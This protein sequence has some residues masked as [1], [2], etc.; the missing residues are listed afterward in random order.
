MTNSGRDINAKGV[1]R[2]RLG[3][4]VAGAL[5]GAIVV[6]VGVIL[7]AEYGLD[8][9]GSGRLL[10]VL[11][12]AEGG[13]EAVASESSSHVQDNAEFE[14]APFESVEYSYRMTIGSSLVFSWVASDE[15]VFNL[16]S[17]PDLVP[18]GAASDYAESFA[19][20]RTDSA[21]GTYTA[22]FTGRHGWFWENRTNASVRL[23]LAAAGFMSAPLRSS[24]SGQETSQAKPALPPDPP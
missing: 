23:R 20:G 18:T 1:T 5:L 22:T 19:T 3:L 2:T 6:V 15:L 12:L 9:L 24:V 21:Q 8:P 16:H 14:L 7:P 4:A 11:G 17:S 13:P 10:G